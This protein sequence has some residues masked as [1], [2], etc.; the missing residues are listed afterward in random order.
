MGLLG[1]WIACIFH[2]VLSS[3]LQ[4]GDDYEVVPGSEF[5]VARTANRLAKDL[6]LLSSD[7]C[8]Y[9]CASNTCSSSKPSR[10]GQSKMR[11]HH[12]MSSLHV[13]ITQQADTSRCTAHSEQHV[14]AMH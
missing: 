14:L 3:M 1:S 7:V 5:T 9:A 13:L 10:C 4:E 2:V 11:Q 6:A 12:A 8:P